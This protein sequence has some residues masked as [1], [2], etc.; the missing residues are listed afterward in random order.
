MNLVFVG[1]RHR[2]TGAIFEEA[3]AD[4]NINV[5]GAWEETE[6]GKQLAEGTGIEFN[7]SSLEEV[8]ADEKVDAVNLGGCYGDRGGHA[9]AALKAGKH[10]Y[11]DKPICTSLAELD[12]IEK[13]SK[14]KGLKVGCYHT[15][16]LSAGMRNIREMIAD[17]TLGEVGAINMTGQHPLQYGT[18][19][20]WYF[21]KGK[22]GGT[23]ND[24]AIHGMDLVRF[25]TGSGLKK[26]H[27]ARV[28]NH[29]ATEVPEF[30]DCG[31]FMVE[32]ENGAGFTADVSYAAPASC[33][34]NLETYWRTTVWGTKGVAEYKLKAQNAGIDSDTGAQL[35]VALDGGAGFEK[36]E[37]KKYDA[38]ALGEFVKEI[39]GETDLIID[40]AE[41]F[42][43]TREILTIQAAADANK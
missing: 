4:P 32:L 22:H 30:C 42:R 11:G 35:M 29:F 33:G 34:F 8:L 24:I 23:I 13:L 27:G 19:P 36:V 25:L 7:Y 43:T 17:G 5:L 6:I 16:R 21:E 9:I 10:V 3:M 28:W 12:E 41:V 40:T 39:N 18:R 31:Q 14:E 38:T 15:M 2:H 20:M 37:L 1:F 26:V